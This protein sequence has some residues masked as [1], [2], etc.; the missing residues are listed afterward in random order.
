VREP[1]TNPVTSY[2]TVGP[3]F[4]IGLKDL[5]RQN[6]TNLKIPGQ[7]IEVAGTIF[8]ADGAGVP[9]AILE[10]WHAD[11]FGKYMVEPQA[12]AFEDSLIGFGRIP[13]NEA[14]EF[15]FRTIKPGPVQEEGSARQSPHILVS[16]FM[17]GLLYRLVTRIYFADEPAN[18]ND[19]V[20]R[21]IEQYRRDTLIAKA[22]PATPN[23]YTWNIF[24]QGEHETVFLEI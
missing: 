10:L 19:P 23:Q 20:L 8:D 18:A 11:S 6:L 16:I 24:L 2:Q 9:D 4:E 5:Y 22:D 13:T 7:A 15:H 14:G 1:P 17:R 3:Y 21:S 12:K